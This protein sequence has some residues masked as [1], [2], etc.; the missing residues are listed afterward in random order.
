LQNTDN[1][2]AADACVNLEPEPGQQ[3]GDPCRGAMLGEA[4]FRVG[5][6]IPPPLGHLAP[7]RLGRRVI[8]VHR[9]LRHQGT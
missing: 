3:F 1:P 4:Q 5:V 8:G 6:K 2:G 7:Q 9:L